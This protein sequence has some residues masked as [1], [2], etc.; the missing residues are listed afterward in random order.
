MKLYA[1]IKR[2][3]KPETGGRCK[4]PATPLQ[5]I[6]G[7][8]EGFCYVKM[9]CEQVGTINSRLHSL[10]SNMRGATKSMKTLDMGKEAYLKSIDETQQRIALSLCRTQKSMDR[11]KNTE[12]FREFFDMRNKK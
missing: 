6:R 4:T 2:G 9:K 1:E 3:S 11:S 5:N 8:F 12:S 10:G 7:G